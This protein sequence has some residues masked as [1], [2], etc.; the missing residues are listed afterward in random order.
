MY[1]GDLLKESVD[2]IIIRQLK[3]EVAALKAELAQQTNNI[4][5]APCP[6]Y[7]YYYE[8]REDGFDW[9]L[10]KHPDCSEWKRRT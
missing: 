1:D 4:A 6:H 5:S 3:T 10:C 9:N 2:S 7:R 8:S